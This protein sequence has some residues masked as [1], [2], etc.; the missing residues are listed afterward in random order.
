MSEE[1]SSNMNAIEEGV[2]PQQKDALKSRLSTVSEKYDIHQSGSL[3]STQMLMRKMDST[4]KGFISN[5]KVYALLQKQNETQK[6]L[7]GYKRIIIILLSFVV[8][9]A[10]ANMGTAFAAATLAKD[11]TTS[12]NVLV[13]KGSGEVVETD[14][15]VNLYQ[16]APSS[17]RR[18]GTAA[19]VDATCA[20]FCTITQ[21][22][23]LDILGKCKQG[24]SV[25]VRLIYTYT[26]GEVLATY[27]VCNANT[28]ETIVTLS[29][30]RDG[31]ITGYNVTSSSGKYAFG[32][33][34]NGWF[35]TVPTS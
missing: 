20:G 29:D 17:S 24:H 12:N 28:V 13:V 8:V 6:K 18:L 5:E 23:A 10:L 30:L 31:T 14:N 33:T 16:V 27:P 22:D 7:L 26:G 9:L 11:T 2:T 25:L 19:T 1:T 15:H 34:T 35:F 21:A 3:D 4:N 32:T